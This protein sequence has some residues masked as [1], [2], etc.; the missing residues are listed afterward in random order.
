MCKPYRILGLALLSCLA[1][2][3]GC[4]G[5]GGD[6]PS[7]ATKVGSAECTNT[8]HAVT[9]DI[10]GTP[11]ADAWANT[12]HTTDGGV[13][14]EDCHGGGSL[15]RGVGNIPY[16]NPQA[17]QCEV[18]HTD[19]KGFD[20]T[21]HANLN[22]YNGTN[23]SSFTGP[24]KFFFQGDALNSGTA[25]IMGVPEFLPD[26]VTPVTHAQHIEECSR[27]HNPNQRFQYGNADGKGELMNPNP[28]KMPDPPNITC[29]GC[30]DAHQAEKKVKIAQRKDS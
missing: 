22:P 28:N 27:C 26:G 4:G 18:C 7:S 12:T 9:K 10:T 17:A 13:Q 21:L 1:L 11:I 2:L 30:H 25:E 24:D 16:P 29:S 19:K 23:L 20:S 15:H 6:R 5:G 8:C 14:C 3:S